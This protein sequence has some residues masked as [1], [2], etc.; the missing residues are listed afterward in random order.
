MIQFIRLID[1]RDKIIKE[2]IPEY[3]DELLYDV[4]EA[5]GESFMILVTSGKIMCLS[6]GFAIIQP[7]ESDILE[8]H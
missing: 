6:C 8:T 2:S 7:G 1:K 5:C 3:F 4:C